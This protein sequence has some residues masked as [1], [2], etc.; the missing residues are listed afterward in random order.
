MADQDA[1]TQDIICITFGQPFLPIKMVEDEIEISPQFEKS[2]HCIFS[3]DDYVPLAL[4]YLP[5]DKREP[6]PDTFH[7]LSKA[8]ALVGQSDAVSTSEPVS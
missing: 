7:S 6:L 2:I 1:L 3:K 4:S 5:V 8:K